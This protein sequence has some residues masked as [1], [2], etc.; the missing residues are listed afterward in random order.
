[1][2]PIGGYL[3]KNLALA[4]KREEIAPMRECTDASKKLLDQIWV[5]T[6]KSVDPAHKKTRP[7]LCQRTLDEETKQHSK[8]FNCFSSVL[9]NAT[10]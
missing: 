3:P 8:S 1:M 7:R 4:A 5:D 9:C 10:T 2:M 6:N